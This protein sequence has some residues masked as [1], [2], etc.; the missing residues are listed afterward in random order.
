MYSR[1]TLL[2]QVLYVLHGAIV[3][4]T[5]FKHKNLYISLF[6]QTTHTALFTMVP[7]NSSQQHPQT[8]AKN[9]NQV[10][11]LN[12]G[13]LF[14][15][16]RKHTRYLVSSR[17]RTQGPPTLPCARYHIYLRA[18]SL[19]TDVSE[20]LP[21]SDGASSLTAHE[22]NARTSAFRIMTREFACFRHSSFVATFCASSKQEPADK[23]QL[24]VEMV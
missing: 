6:L 7:R 12:L 21:A 17:L 20:S 22:F 18:T 5:Y 16:Q 2:Y 19:G 4:R 15:G 14:N 10:E 24:Y 9:G 13:I 8:R 23:Y 11:S 3:N 1:S